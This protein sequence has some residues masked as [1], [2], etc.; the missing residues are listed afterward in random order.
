MAVGN[1]VVTAEVILGS[2]AM[3]LITK[4]SSQR[5]QLKILSRYLLQF[6]SIREHIL[7]QQLIRFPEGMEEIDTQVS[8]FGLSTWKRRHSH[9]REPRLRACT[10]MPIRMRWHSA[11]GLAGHTRSTAYDFRIR[12]RGARQAVSDSRAGVRETW[13]PKSDYRTELHGAALAVSIG[14]RKGRLISIG[15]I[16]A[17]DS[18]GQQEQNAHTRLL[19]HTQDI[20]YALARPSCGT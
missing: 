5:L 14:R 3:Q 11:S 10:H 9:E 1:Q 13:F 17:R 7:K 16:G 8:I 15:G 6:Q 18:F 19:P 20:A 2:N 4:V 12:M